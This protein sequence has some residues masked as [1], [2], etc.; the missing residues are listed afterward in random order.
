[1]GNRS[2]NKESL[3]ASYNG[4]I[5]YHNNLVQTRFTVVGLVL[6]ANGFLVS[7]FFQQAC[8]DLPQ[9][10]IPFL[11][12]ILVIIIW[13]MEI[14]THCLL[15][16]LGKRG[17]KIEKILG[18]DKNLRFFSLMKK[19]PLGPQFL[20]LRFIRFHPNKFFRYFFSH[21]FGIGLLYFFLALFWL[22]ILALHYSKHIIIFS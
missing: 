4:I 8:P 1:M 7:V 20:I 12:I 19:Q 6:A 14:R 11:S 18:I 15:E 5:D 21:S 10:I 17:K 22:I 9:I 16:N 13:M 3:R 2:Y